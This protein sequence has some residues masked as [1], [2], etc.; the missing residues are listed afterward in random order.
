RSRSVT[1]QTSHMAL[2]WRSLFK[3][4]FGRDESMNETLVQR[5]RA[6]LQPPVCRVPLAA[7]SIAFLNGQQIESGIIT[8]AEDSDASVNVDSRFVVQSISKSFTAAVILRLVESDKLR[9]D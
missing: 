6:Y 3:S 1:R 9:L 4:Y 8:A 5:V 7:V 2:D